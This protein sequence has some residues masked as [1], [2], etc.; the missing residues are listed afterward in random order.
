[1]P[2]PFGF[3]NEKGRLPRTALLIEQDAAPYAAILSFDFFATRRRANRPA[4]AA[5]N[6]KTIGGAGTSV[7]PVDPPDPPLDEELDED[8]DDE[9]LLEEV[10]APLEPEDVPPKD[11]EVLP[12][13][14]PKLEELPDDELDEDE[15][16]DEDELLEP[17]LPDEPLDPELPEEPL[18]PELPEDPLEPLL[19]PEPP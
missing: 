18:E 15:L 17:E 8:E 14:P 6:S 3:R 9:L 16:D 1:M 19:P 12:P 4:A 5:P 2:T 10:D 11:D 7:P 13:L